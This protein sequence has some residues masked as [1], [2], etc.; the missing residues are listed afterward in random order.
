MQIRNDPILVVGSVRICAHSKRSSLLLNRQV[1]SDVVRFAQQKRST[2][3]LR[4][5]GVNVQP[6]VRLIL[7]VVTL[8]LCV[9][10]GEAL[11]I[12]P[13][14]SARLP[15]QI[16]DQEFWRMVTDFSEPQG[17]YTGDNWIS[18]EAS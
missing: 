16:T 6:R 3:L 4:R 7:A 10:M 1:H 14:Q 5:S 12:E 2:T 15:D 18:N 8:V 11:S 9:L 17:L 13:G